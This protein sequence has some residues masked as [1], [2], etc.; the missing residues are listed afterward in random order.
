MLLP[1]LALLLLSVCSASIRRNGR[2]DSLSVQTET[3]LWQCDPCV[4]RHAA[5]SVAVCVWQK[6][7]LLRQS[8]FFL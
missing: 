2:I 6:A 1:I 8:M 7:N 3:Y 5:V 4:G